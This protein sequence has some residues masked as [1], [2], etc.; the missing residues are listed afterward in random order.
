VPSEFSR[1]KSQ[2]ETEI[3]TK[4]ADVKSPLSWTAERRRLLQ[5]MWDRGDKVSEIAEALGRKPCAVNVERARFGLKTRRVWPSPARAGR[6]GAH[7]RARRLR[8]VAPVGILQ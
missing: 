4:F 8:H 5:E 3:F 2:P 7:D 6:T 1:L